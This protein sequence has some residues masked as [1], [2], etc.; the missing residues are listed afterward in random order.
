MKL[1]SF[2]S[3][4][5]F[6]KDLSVPVY[7]V[8]EYLIILG[9]LS[10]IR[11][12]FFLFH[13]GFWQEIPAADLI[14]AFGIGI[15]FDSVVACYILVLPALLLFLPVKARTD[16]VLQTARTL[17]SV[18]TVVVMVMSLADI[19]YYEFF[20]NHLDH[21]AFDYLDSPGDVIPMLWQQFPVIGYLIFVGILVSVYLY[22]R[23]IRLNLKPAVYPRSHLNLSSVTVVTGTLLLLFIGIRG[24]VTSIPIQWGDAFVT[25]SEFANQLG[26]SPAFTFFNALAEGKE[27]QV[28]YS[29]RKELDRVLKQAVVLPG[30]QPSGTDNPLDRILTGRG[31]IQGK[32][33]LILIILESWRADM[34]GCLG[35]STRLTP[36]FD[37]LA[38]EGILFEQFYASGIRS[39]R[40]ILSVV[41]SFPGYRGGSMM[42]KVSGLTEFPTAASI[43]KPYGWASASFIYGGD[44]TFDN[45][46]SF[47]K[48]NGFDRFTGVESFSEAEY[49]SHWGA[50]DRALF[51]KAAT[52]LESYQEPFISLIFTLTTHEPFTYPP[53]LKETGKAVGTERERFYNLVAYSDGALGDFFA[54]IRSKPFFRNSVFIIC[55]DHT[56]KF[57]DPGL[58]SERFH[59]PALIY[60]PLLADLKGTRISQPAG[61]SDLLPT[62]LG[63]L[64]GKFRVNSWGRDVFRTDRNTA[65]AQFNTNEFS[66]LVSGGQIRY[67][68]LKN[69]ECFSTD[70]AGNRIPKPEENQTSRLDSL[71]KAITQGSFE[72]VYEKRNGIQRD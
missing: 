36:V 4:S 31:L 71:N 28:Y 35:D 62:V 56:K 26:L 61:H 3:F 64:D 8:S 9:I 60:S 7:L 17:I 18:L 29:D 11:V 65:W 46:K 30:D 20:G 24:K 21:F 49:G 48:T 40:G 72:L 66:G 50:S 68:N 19:R 2:F 70:L 34:T 14:T 38:A 41:S 54:S 6:R 55:A 39:N 22:I 51:K 15:W 5:G 27:W 10:G 12:A 58:S 47:L 45:M 25:E 57:S 67:L 13:S 16:R 23:H 37:S 63:F 32:P 59:I 42:K 69:G 33:N 53:D 52:E 43:L 44:Q 1:P